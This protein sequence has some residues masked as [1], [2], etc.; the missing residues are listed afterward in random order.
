M[1]PASA[2][3]KGLVESLLEELSGKANAVPVKLFKIAMSVVGGGASVGVTVVGTRFDV[4]IALDGVAA[5]SDDAAAEG[6]GFDC[7]CIPNPVAGPGEEAGLA[8]GAANTDTVRDSNA[9]AVSAVSEATTVTVTAF[10]FGFSVT[11]TVTGASG[12]KD[13]FTV[14]S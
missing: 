14:G 5:E 6:R 7:V 10:S 12:P 13:G 4:G 2:D 11:V 1:Q 9:G 3:G 8:D